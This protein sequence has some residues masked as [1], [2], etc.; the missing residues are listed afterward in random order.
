MLYCRLRARGNDARK[1]RR[2]LLF[3][4]LL[5][6]GEDHAMMVACRSRVVSAVRWVQ[7]AVSCTV[8]VCRW[9]GVSG[10][11]TGQR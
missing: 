11:S 1:S 4:I 6:G 10:K 5:V 8:C 9:S 3:S 7:T 2:R